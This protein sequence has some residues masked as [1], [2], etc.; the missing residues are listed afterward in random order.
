MTNK[1]VKFVGFVLLIL[2]LG[3]VIYLIFYYLQNP[4]QT[5]D[6]PENW[7]SELGKCVDGY[8]LE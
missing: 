2:F 8:G 7:N 5:C 4:S 1:I 3:Y 6:Y